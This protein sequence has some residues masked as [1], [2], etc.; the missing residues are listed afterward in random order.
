MES[1]LTASRGGG[2]G[3]RVMEQKGKRTHGRGQQCGDC[4]MGGEGDYMVVEKYNKKE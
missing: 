4:G 2:E 3:G 1:R